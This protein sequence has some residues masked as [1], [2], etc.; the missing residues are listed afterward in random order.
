MVEKRE[1]Y[2]VDRSEQYQE[3]DDTEFFHNAQFVNQC[4]FKNDL[5]IHDNKLVDKIKT[6]EEAA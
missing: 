4:K 3:Q 6:F 5:M 2:L 1:S